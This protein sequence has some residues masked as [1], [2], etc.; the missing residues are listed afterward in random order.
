MIIYRVHKQEKSVNCYRYKHSEL[1]R[2]LRESNFIQL[3]D[4]SSEGAP[5]PDKPVKSTSMFPLK[6][7]SSSSISGRRLSLMI[8]QS[9]K[10]REV[11]S[12]AFYYVLCYVATWALPYTN[13]ILDGQKTKVPYVLRLM[14]RLI[15]PGQGIWN[16]LVYTRPHVI[17]LRRTNPEYSWLK[18]FT[19]VVKS[20]GDNDG[21]I[22][23]RKA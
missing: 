9:K 13:N 11:M 8:N 18:A 23:R 19:I 4:S 1:R 6:R 15:N 22:R 14:A 2:S 20:G 7:R 3:P 17:S 5:R 12:Q 16:I 21:S 10:H